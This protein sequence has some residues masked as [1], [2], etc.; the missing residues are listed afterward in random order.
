MGSVDEVHAAI[1]QVELRQGDKL[2]ICSDGISNAVAHHELAEIL[3][4]NSP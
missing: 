2:L 1:A 3:S 4:V